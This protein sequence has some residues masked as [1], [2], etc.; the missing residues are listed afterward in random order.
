MLLLGN[1]LHARIGRVLYKLPALCSILQSQHASLP[2]ISNGHCHVLQT[3]L[4][5]EQ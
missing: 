2:V 3:G 5:K 1:C 4:V